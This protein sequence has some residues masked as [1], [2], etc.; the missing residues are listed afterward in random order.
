M[1]A[2]FDFKWEIHASV[3]G[4]SIKAGNLNAPAQYSTSSDIMSARRV[5]V[6]AGEVTRVVVVG[7][8]DTSVASATFCAFVPNVDGSFS[9]TS[10]SQGT[11]NAASLGWKA[12][13]PLMFPTG[14]VLM[15]N[16]VSATM[17]AGTLED[18]FRVYFYN[19]GSTDG[20][21]EILVMK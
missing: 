8:D 16:A 19:S 4:K 21:V 13:V 3:A 18:L 20:Y 11:N 5:L 17:V 9:W 7:G 14:Q 10:A 12:G 2:T 1:A 15:Y 6:P